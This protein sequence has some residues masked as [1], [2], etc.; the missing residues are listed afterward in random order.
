MRSGTLRLAQPLSGL[1][2]RDREH[3][4]DTFGDDLPAPFAGTLTCADGYLINALQSLRVYDHTD[5]DNTGTRIVASKRVAVAYG[6]DTDQA[7]GPDPIQDTGYSV[8]P[9][10]QDWLA[11]VLVLAKSVTPATVP[12]AGG[13]ASY[14]LTVQSFDFGPLANLAVW[15]CLP[16][17]VPG[18]AY[19]PGTTL[20]TY[21]NL[22]Q[23]VNDPA[24]VPA[25]APGCPVGRDQLVWALSPDQL[26][27]IQTLTVR[28]D[29]NIPAGPVAQLRNEARADATFGGS[30]FS[31][32]AVADIVRTD[33]Q[34]VKSAADD[35]T[36]EPGDTIDY[37][38]QIAN[39]GPAETNAVIIDPVP[40]DTTFL[41]GSIISSGP[42]AGI[43]DSA[44]N[45]VVWTAAVFPTSGPFSL[46]YTVTVNLGVAQG[47]RITNVANY[48]SDQTPN[49]PS[50]EVVTTIVSPALVASKTA[51]L[52]LLHP[53][54]TVTFS[55]FVRNAGAAT[56]TNVQ[57]L[58]DIPANT[59]YVAGSMQWQRNAGVFTSLTDAADVDAGT[60]VGAQLRFLLSSLAPNEDLTFRFQVQVDPGTG[61]SFV[62]NQATVSATSITP[63]D[64]NLVQIP[65]VGD[66]DVTGHVFL[67][68]DGNGAQNPG[69]PNIANVDVVLT[70]AGGM[71]QTVTTD[72]NGN[73]LATVDV[74]GGCPYRDDADALA[75]NGTNGNTN[76]S[77]T[78]WFETSDD[79]VPTSGDVQVVVEPLGV[80]GN[81]FR[82]N[83][84]P[85]SNTRALSRPAD[86]T[87][88]TGAALSFDYR[89]VSLEATDI[90]SIEVSYN[91]GGTF[92]TLANLGNGADATWQS[93]SLTLDAGQLPTNQ[94]VIRFR[95]NNFNFFNDEFYFDNVR[96]CDPTVTA[97]VDET[98][99]DFP[100]GATLTTANDPQTVVAVAGG[101][102]AT[103]AVGYQPPNITFTKSSDAV[104]NQ[105]SPGQTLTYT[106]TMTNNTGVTQTG[107][108]VAD[109][110]PTGT[111]Y[112]P[113]SSQVSL[114]GSDSMRVTEYF[115]APGTFGGTV[116][117]L[118]LNQALASDYFVVLEGSAGAGTGAGGDR[119]P[120]VN[121]ARV[122]QDPSGTGDLGT[123]AGANVIRIERGAVQDSWVG[124]VKVVECLGNCSSAG[125][126]LLDVQVVAHGA[127]N[128]AP[129]TGTDTSGTTWS[130]INQV[131]LM[132]GFNGP[133]CLTT[134]TGLLDHKL[135]HVR[136]APTGTD[137]I[138]WSRDQTGSAFFLPATSTVMVVEWGSEWTVQR[139]RIQ[140]NSGADGAN[141]AGAYD[142]A[143]ISPV[144]RADTWVW[145]TGFTTGASVG[146]AGEGILLTLG[147]GVTQ[148]ATESTLAA[149]SEFGNDKDF[150]VYAIT[151]PSLAV[152][153]EFKADGDNGALTVDV[154]V[155]AAT[156]DRMALVT[157]GLGGT[158]NDYPRSI[159]SSRY[160]ADTTARIERRRSGATFPAWVQ[161]IDFSGLQAP[162]VI[163]PG[164]A[165]PGLVIPADGY[166]LGPGQTLVVTFQVLVAS[167]LA[168]GIT[169]I[170]NTGTFQSDQ[171]GPINAS[172]TDDV[173]RVGVIVEPNN[174]GFT[175][176]GSTITYSHNV[177][178]TGGLA[179][180]FD[181]TLSSERGW[182]VELL[183]PDTG[184]V[185]ATDSNGD[186]VWDGGVTVNTGTLAPGG[187]IDYEVR[188]RV[189]GGTPP[190]TQDTT[191]L[192]AASDRNPAVVGV[193]TDE[194]TVLDPADIGPIILIPDQ[195]GVVDPG[196]SVV[197]PHRVFNNTGLTD[198]FDLVATPTLP[199]WTATFYFDNNGDGVYTPGVDIAI[200]N[201]AVLPD[202]GSQ[203]LFVVVTAPPGAMPGDAD[204]ANL[205]A[206]SRNDTDLLDTASD[207]TTVL[208][209][210]SHDLAGGGTFLVNGGAT[211]V[212]PGTL[213]NLGEASDV[214]DLDIGPST[215]VDAFSHPTQLWVD[216]ND[217][218]SADTMIAEDLDGDGV[219]DTVDPAWDS[220]LNGEPDVPVAAGGSLAYELRRAVDVNQ[221][222]VRDPVTL[223]STSL[224]TGERDSI[225]ATNL[226]AL[227]TLAVLSDFQVRVE[228]GQVIVEWST[229]AESGT[230]GF[231]LER[232][233][234]Q[235]GFRRLNK[236]M[237]PGLLNSPQ[238]GDY[239]F[240]DTTARS[241][242]A[243][244]YRLVEREIWGGDR[245]L[246]ASPAQL[247]FPDATPA[248]AS[249]VQPATPV[250]SRSARRTSVRQRV[251]KQSTEDAPPLEVSRAAAG[252]VSALAPNVRPGTESLSAARRRGDVVPLSSTLGA[253][254]PVGAAK[255]V[256]VDAGL[257]YVSLDSLSSALETSVSRM[258]T[259]MEQGH[260]EL[261][262]RGEE[263]AW[264]RGSDANG[265]FFY[266][267]KLD[268]IY[269]ERN[270][271]WLRVAPGA[272]M[273]T[274][275]GR[276]RQLPVSQGFRAHLHLEQE[277]WGLLSVIDDP[278]SDF[279]FWDFLLGGVPGYARREYV[280]DVPGVSGGTGMATL[281]VHLQGAT[282]TEA[283]LDH[284]ILAVLNGNPLDGDGTWDGT[285]AKT[286]WFDFPQAWLNEGPNT[287]ELNSLLLPG[288]DFDFVYLDS[289]DLEY[290]R[291]YR[292]VGDVLDA[293]AEGLRTI[294]IDGFSASD[295][296]VFDLSVPRAPR[297]VKGAQVEEG[298]SGYLVRFKSHPDGRY[299]AMRLAAAQEPVSVIPDQPSALASERNSAEYVVI[300]PP[301]F[302]AGAASLAE[303]RAAQGL[304]TLVAKL[305]DVY[306]EFSYGIASPLAIRAFLERAGT[307]WGDPPRYVVLAGDGTYDY[308]DRMGYGAN[309][310]PPLMVATP[311]GLVPSDNRLAD[312]EGDDGI[313]ELAIGRLPV[314]SPAELDAFVA[315]LAAYQS[316]KGSWRHESLWL[317]DDPDEGGEFGQD[318]ERLI[319]ALDGKLGVERV[320]LSNA[321]EALEVRQKLF[322]GLA[323]GA[324]LVNYLGH[325]GFDRLA[326]EG[327]LVTA[328]VANLGNGDRLPVV[329]ALSC[330]VGRFDVPG[331]DTL[332]EALI[333]EETGGAIA[334][335]APAGFSMNAGAT[336]V[337]EGMLAAIAAD[338]APRLGDAL[339][340]GLEH[341][342]ATADPAEAH[343]PFIYSLLG[344]PATQPGWQN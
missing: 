101:T 13:V 294:E 70:S 49:F 289:F 293:R 315:K 184:V 15:D 278:A 301:G 206:I 5:Y 107:V 3:Q 17:G 12:M 30:M 218:G 221:T 335:V 232:R 23:G 283:D 343:L 270:V 79:G 276:P 207:T 152:D 309:W 120:A 233:G 61:G 338:E 242:H 333:L 8:Y 18:S 241:G 220:N 29:I 86:L 216:T 296:T 77:P 122:T 68:L 317:A 307:A 155:S 215:V 226:L 246:T 76:W 38:L 31:P 66:A 85:V 162:P 340:A 163:A 100:G 40:P 63:F 285:T 84:D 124:V 71:T 141:A 219:W 22:S 149:G 261:R 280:L 154:G 244:E 121:Y 92:A 316:T 98:D 191:R 328:D 173:V 277:F 323:E 179:D 50:N 171:E 229:A 213:F 284:S 20:I 329:A 292:A 35:G 303:L 199:G 114:P 248:D 247:D 336:I 252:G 238:G 39:I 130:D 156:A 136:F 260:L 174:A 74:A 87:G 209:A 308:K 138:N 140:G 59:T 324:A 161:G 52:A 170:V 183:D 202:G 250:Y 330:V 43:Y 129:L 222:P 227:A 41:P 145:G 234:T 131:M 281:Q 72:A 117:D 83:G 271:Y 291:A 240:V 166:T 21:P 24:V 282:E 144:A 159:L 9:L 56:A 300:A 157:N 318:S 102:V 334:L 235:G 78:P 81:S 113:G 105:V 344:D 99:P 259:L 134:D 65:I 269:S 93:Q 94:L 172:V 132:G 147:D 332:G 47:T 26:G 104:A 192:T 97:D 249:R 320:Y 55:V 42:F 177:L 48:E 337:G 193:G 326:D 212:F 54:E 204:V 279:W 178:N 112:V 11:P 245:V 96:I 287:I 126:S 208:I 119:I 339:L 6:E 36:P 295:I 103:A 1:R 182:V 313:P 236:R 251:P 225:T 231:H 196:G 325:G 14:L 80:F 304:S 27:L 302:E 167:P 128:P 169:Q 186:G 228:E 89:R 211:A 223:A 195:S 188:I 310:I 342:L 46:G 286:L 127:G 190:D 201:T 331:F 194:T 75:Y 45:A 321:G 133:G 180:S 306:D 239:R 142:T 108:S 37:T 290:Q 254:G 197:Y 139:R 185:I 91:G 312:W 106:L 73:Y 32:S 257:V 28:Y 95:T 268:S 164:N 203:L 82:L 243:Y 275:A 198:T 187:V 64:T 210:T 57:I 69:E 62:N 135:C 25:P 53:N 265:I 10:N 258:R 158:G 111:S 305:E 181:I 160:F 2:V 115:I 137:T 90:V 311:N 88:V 151:H 165:P 58:D 319:A 7:T 341:Y 255:I 33:V 16:V 125:F 189:P 262:S 150:E 4:V 272:R 123:S 51:D 273:A 148:N 146:E 264:M 200:T 110:V 298:A 263:V 297:L 44:Q 118:T 327:L 153:Y 116:F 214:F 176:P 253:R 267:E 322:S 143:A 299:L 266:A 19:A 237:L 230:L 67:D 109:A 34:L 256:V 217:D 274:V 288:V 60:L 314:Q 205:A 175:T 224:L 168:P